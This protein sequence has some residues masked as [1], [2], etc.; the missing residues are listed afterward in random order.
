MSRGDKGKVPV[1]DHDLPETNRPEERIFVD[2]T[3]VGDLKIT[4]DEAVERVRWF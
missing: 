1:Q 4:C 3:N 2:N